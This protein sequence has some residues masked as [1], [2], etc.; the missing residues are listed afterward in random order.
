MIIGWS[1][2]NKVQLFAMNGWTIPGQTLP[3]A[4][5]P[6]TK[7]H[8]SMNRRGSSS[9]YLNVELDPM[10]KRSTI[11][12]EATVRT[13][14]SYE[15][16]YMPFARAEDGEVGNLVAVGA[17]AIV[18]ADRRRP[19]DPAERGPDLLL[20]AQ[21]SRDKYLR[22]GWKGKQEVGGRGVCPV[23]GQWHGK[24][25][26][27]QVLRDPGWTCV[28]YVR[29]GRSS[30]DIFMRVMFDTIR[31]RSI[32]LHSVTVKLGLRASGGPMWLGH[33]GE[34]RRYSSCMYEVSVLDWKGRSEWIK[35]RG[36][37]YT[38]PSEQRDMPEG[39]RETFP[40]IAWSSVMV[41]QA[42]GPVDMIIGRDNPEWMPV[43]VQEEP[44]ERFT[45][46]WTS[47]S[48]RYILR[49]NDGISW[50]L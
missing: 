41:S 18:R 12:H 31:E 1:D 50:R 4:T 8:L 32:I 11:T 42:A 48:P 36:V 37:S 35:A 49:E 19:A 38:T 10:R 26:G 3:G 40:E 7:W 14:E 25:K 16:F 9:I 44:Y 22:P 28:Q 34:D 20:D 24:L 27:R 33:R 43:P 45:L 39:A 5:A 30:E 6:A 47:L 29:T 15:P 17:N 13:G 23:K 21:D 2:W 46:M